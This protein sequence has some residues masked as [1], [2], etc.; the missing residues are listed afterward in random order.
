M[1]EW[2]LGDSM[3][4][5]RVYCYD[6]RGTRRVRQ[7]GASSLEDYHRQLNM[8]LRVMIKYKLVFDEIEIEVLDNIPF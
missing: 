6:P 3:V 7:F 4:L 8:I 5:V 1:I 2:F